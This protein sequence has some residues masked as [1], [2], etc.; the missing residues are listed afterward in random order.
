M[1]TTIV[2]REEDTTLSPFSVTPLPPFDFFFPESNISVRTTHAEFIISFVP[3]LP[4][5]LSLLFLNLSTSEVFLYNCSLLT[6]F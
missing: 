2:D 3:L 5:F 4:P 1:V 6:H